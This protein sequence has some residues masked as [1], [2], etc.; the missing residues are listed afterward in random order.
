MHT[1]RFVHPLLSDSISL[2]QLS[3]KTSFNNF[4]CVSLLHMCSYVLLKFC[5]KRS[6][7]FCSLTKINGSPNQISSQKSTVE[8]LWSVALWSTSALR[9]DAHH[10]IM[11]KMGIFVGNDDFVNLLEIF[12]GN[13]DFV[14]NEG[15]QFRQI[16]FVCFFSKKGTPFLKLGHFPKGKGK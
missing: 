6:P 5:P 2:N 10:F 7:I 16:R 1:P 12:V 11:S 14:G 9:M 8:P 13:D 3:S 4:S 15:F